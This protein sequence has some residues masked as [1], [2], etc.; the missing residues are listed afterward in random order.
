M[1]ESVAP[2]GNLIFE[3]VRIGFRNFAGVEGK[4]NK[5][6]QRNFVVFLDTPVAEE[7]ALD[8]W[9]IKWL[10]PRD[11]DEEAQAY[12]QV[13]ANFGQRPPKIVTIT[14]RGKTE[15]DESSIGILDWAEIQKVDL[16]IRPYHWEVNGKS[17]TKAYLRTLFVHLV[18]DELEQKYQDV[19]DSAA[20]SMKI[21]EGEENEPPF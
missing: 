9:N 1:S 12:L 17:G 7:M 3:D 4:Y 18:E 20:N 8:G 2:R 13:S 11:E 15:L 19:P 10:N 16:S 14:S 21:V 6:G 5:E